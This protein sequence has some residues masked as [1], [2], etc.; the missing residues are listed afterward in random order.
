MRRWPLLLLLAALPLGAQVTA[1]VTDSDGTVWAGGKWTATRTGNTTLIGSL[2]SAGMLSAALPDVTNGYWTFLICPNA[3]AS[4]YSIQP[5]LTSLTQNFTSQIAAPGPRFQGANSAYGYANVEVLTT[6]G[7]AA[8]YYNVATNSSCLFNGSSWTCTAS[9]GG[10]ATLPSNLSAVATDSSGT[11][12]QATAIPAAD[13]SGLA[14][15]ATTDTTNGIN[16]T[17]GTVGVA[18]LPSYVANMTFTSGSLSKT[19]T[20]GLNTQYPL[21]SMATISG[22]TGCVPSTTTATTVTYT[23]PAPANIIV[24]AMAGAQLAAVVQTTPVLTW[25]TPAAVTQGTALSSTQLNATSNVPG[26]FVYSPPAGTVLNTVGT[27]VLSTAF[28]PTDTTTYANANATVSQ[29]VNAASRTANLLY[30]WPCSEGTGTTCAES[31]SGN[32]A[33]LTG[34]TWS[35]D[36]TFSP[37]TAFAGTTGNGGL[38]ANNANAN[39]T[40]TTPFSLSAWI[41]IGSSASGNIITDGVNNGA[42]FFWYGSGLSMGMALLNNSSSNNNNWSAAANSLTANAWNHVVVTYDGTA[43]VSAVKFYVNGALVAQPTGSGNGTLTG[44]I[45]N[46]VNAL[47]FGK[48]TDGSSPFTGGMKYER[49]YGAVLAA[50]DVAT[51]YQNKN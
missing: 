15:S 37:Y 29:V 34:N 44:S 14:P 45:A 46:T 27:Q 25:A 17:T 22:S 26:S 1:T 41:K 8:S 21:L 11:P 38:S 4:C 6:S 10:P 32:T 9:G 39:F 23:C 36:S 42:G 51:I 47:A 35:S 18:R 28:T 5:S 31:V 19:F 49:I 16:I 7:Q 24:T 3:S 2:N 12:R 13:I 20:H 30:Y 50:S 33:T 48:N 43:G 40:N